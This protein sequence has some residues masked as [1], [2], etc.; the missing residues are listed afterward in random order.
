MGLSYNHF[1]CRV[2]RPPSATAST[3][4]NGHQQLYWSHP[5]KFRQGSCSCRV[6]SNRH[7]LICKYGLNMCRQCFHQY[8]KDIGFI[9]L[10]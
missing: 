4:T 1:H 5:R 6:R 3:A 7:S 10:D 9:K 8:T 2:R